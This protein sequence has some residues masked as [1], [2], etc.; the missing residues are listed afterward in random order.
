[1][2]NVLV[3]EDDLHT[4]KYI[5]KLLQ[6][7]GFN[8][9]LAENG[10]VALKIIGDYHIDVAIIDVM[11]PEMNGYELTDFLRKNNYNMPLLMVTA[12]GKIEDKK[13]GFLVGIDDYLV[14]PFE[15]EELILRINALLRRSKIVSEHKLVIGD[16]ILDYDSLT[17]TRL[18]KT[19]EL[20]KKEF[21][22]LYKLLSYPNVIFTR[23]QLMDEIW[24]MDSDSDDK[25]ITVHINRLRSQFGDFPEFEIQT[26]RGLGYKAVKK[27]WK[28]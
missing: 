10:S 26:I 11:M 5:G 14:K 19:F 12:K 16:V 2:F 24:G 8:P 6:N 18:D 25:T 4:R 28:I 15:A 1:M 27:I 17:V 7:N 22:L 3:A 9:I 21:Y 13:K 20:P 23:Y